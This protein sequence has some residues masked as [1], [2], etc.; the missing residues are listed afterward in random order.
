[1]EI[2]IMRL[3]HLFVA[4]SLLAVS[5]VSEAQESVSRR[6]LACSQ[7]SFLVNGPGWVCNVTPRE[8]FLAGAVATD[9]ELAMLRE[10]IQ[11]LTARIEKLEKK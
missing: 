9:T 5:D 7:W 10:E 11:K 8:I 3:T 4:L 6:V 2:L 1:M